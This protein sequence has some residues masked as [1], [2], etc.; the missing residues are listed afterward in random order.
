[1]PALR[2][3]QEQFVAALFDSAD[4]RAASH[5]VANGVTPV[6]RL[7]IY[8][9][10][11]RE[12]F[13]KALAI[14]YPVVERLVGVDYFRQLALEFQK[15]HPS[16]AGNLHHAAAPFPAYL[17]ERFAGT[18]FTY[19]ADV[20]AL[21]RAHE[22]ALI[23]AEA[24]AI[25]ADA[26]RGI[27][28]D[29]YEHLRFELHPACSLVQ[30]AY[31]IVRIWRANQSDAPADDIIDIDSGGDTVLVLRTPECIEFHFLPAAEFAALD[32]L[33]RGEPLGLALERAQATDPDFDL[34]AALRRFITLK[35]FAGVSA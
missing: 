34:G 23:A 12:G 3:L 8:R 15:A 30:S 28:P 11:L 24:E 16:R 32:A 17:R 9:N 21:E 14:A 13:I 26:L 20:A 10:N 4:E 27:A 2:E 29:R 1:M 31:P 19:L 7:D 33:A 25:T 35:V 22:E 18:E 5:I 6:E